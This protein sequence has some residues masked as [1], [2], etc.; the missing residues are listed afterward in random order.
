MQY[1][2]IED[3]P[4]GESMVRPDCRKHKCT[5]PLPVGNRSNLSSGREDRVKGTPLS[6]AKYEERIQEHTFVGRRA[7]GLGQES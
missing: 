6:E 2:R 3:D 4:N 7:M 1:S 5:T